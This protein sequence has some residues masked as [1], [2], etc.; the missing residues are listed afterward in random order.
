MKSQS[1]IQISPEREYSTENKIMAHASV[2]GIGGNVVLCAFKLTAG[3]FGHSSAMV[4][5]GVHSLSDVFATLIALIGTKV[6]RRGADREHP[7]GHDRF[8]CIAS[9]AL[10]TILL[11][12]GLGIGIAGIR[13]ILSGSYAARPVPGVLPMAAAIV[14]IAVKEVMFWYTRACAKKI[15]SSAFMADAWHHRSD[16]LSSVG[17]LIG[18]V[19]A[20]AGVLIL[21]PIASILICCFILK[22][23]VDILR[24]AV[25]K[26]TDTACDEAYTA[27]VHSFIESQEGVRRIDL[28]RTREFGE[29]VYIDVEI[30]VDADMPL[31]DAHAIAERVHAGIEQTFD[32]V[33]HVM[34]HV[35]PYTPVRN[36]EI[37]RMSDENFCG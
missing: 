34:V 5:D 24:D 35:N 16:A 30:A 8:E 13:T 22:M 37:S 36:A 17:S 33:K 28:L 31:I 12:T 29:M 26:L 14:S 32:N 1:D 4:S 15:H 20:R 10:A 23:G 7:Y 6:S 21:D 11:V 9:E 19:G 3:F 18:I 27:Q 2:T 25:N